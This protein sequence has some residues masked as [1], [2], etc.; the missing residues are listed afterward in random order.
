MI[1]AIFFILGLVLGL[2]MHILLRVFIGVD[3]VFIIDDGDPTTTRWTLQMKTDPREIS[4]KKYVK[5]K[6]DS[7]GRK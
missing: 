6:V 1:Y 3:G 7:G 5:M 2:G 4:K